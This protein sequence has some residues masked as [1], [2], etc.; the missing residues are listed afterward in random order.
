MT[1]ADETLVESAQRAGEAVDEAQRLLQPPLHGAVAPSQRDGDLGRDRAHRHLA[2][3]D[4]PGPMPRPV[5]GD[6]HRGREVQRLLRLEGGD[7]RLRSDETGD[8]VGQDGI[9]TVVEQRS[10]WHVHMLP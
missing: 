2:L 5:E 7:G 1:C 10:I 8:G 4:C 6:P 9:L 3:L